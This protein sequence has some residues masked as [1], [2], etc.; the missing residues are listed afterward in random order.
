MDGMG[1]NGMMGSGG[2]QA[3]CQSMKRHRTMPDNDGPAVCDSGML[4]EVQEISF[5][6]TLPLLKAVLVSV[7]PYA[8]GPIDGF[9]EH[10]LSPG[11]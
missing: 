9:S 11:E 2:M 6:K 5:P 3:Q 7:V 4:L 8:E 10:E 1:Q